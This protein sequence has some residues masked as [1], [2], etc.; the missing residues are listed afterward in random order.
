[1]QKP[2]HAAW[3]V[4]HACVR[5]PAACMECFRRSLSS[6]RMIRRCL[7]AMP[8]HPVDKAK[9]T[10]PD[11]PQTVLIALPPLPICPCAP[12]LALLSSPWG[13]ELLRAPLPHIPALT[14]LAS[15]TDR[16]A[17]CRPAAPPLSPLHNECCVHPP[18]PPAFL[19]LLAGH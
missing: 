2:P 9:P 14:C 11:R 12:A 6:G 10:P 7:N 16:D 5:L 4:L 18:N 1:M 19:H 3:L 17:P 13:T 15:A 8:K